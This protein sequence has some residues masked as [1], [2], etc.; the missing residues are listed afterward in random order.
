MKTNKMNRFFS[1]FALWAVSLSVFA[2]Q[3]GNLRTQSYTNP[4]GIDITSPFQPTPQPPFICLWQRVM[5]CLRVETA[6]LP[7]GVYIQGG[8]K[9]AKLPTVISQYF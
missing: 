2:L 9:T 1:L 5:N 8:K 6:S 3:V 7:H 4:I